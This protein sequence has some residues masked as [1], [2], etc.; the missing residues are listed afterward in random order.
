MIIDSMREFSRYC[1]L[2]TAAWEKLSAF[3]NSLS[4]TI[5][6]PGSHKLDGDKL[7]VNIVHT[8]TSPRENGKYEVHR[9]YID[10]HIPIRGT[11][12]I[13][14]RCSSDGLK[15]IGAFDVENDYVFFEPEPG[16][17]CFLEPGY[18]LM[19]YPGEVHHVLTGDGSPIIKAI[20]KIDITLL[21]D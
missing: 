6:E 1:K 12:T 20:V 4:G 3:L 2:A 13:I 17:D 9:Q 10:I 21:Q 11:E 15:Q 16:L 18:F 14:C 7:K 5:P 19:L 8:N